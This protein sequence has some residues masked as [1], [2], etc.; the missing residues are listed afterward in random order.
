VIHMNIYLDHIRK[1]INVKFDFYGKNKNI[2]VRIRFKEKTSKI[3]NDFYSL[4][5][6]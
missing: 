1:F 5:F 4:N 2:K 6:I 3:Y